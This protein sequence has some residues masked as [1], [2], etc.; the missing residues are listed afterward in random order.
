MAAQDYGVDRLGGW[1]AEAD[2]VLILG[3]GFEI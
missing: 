1:P 2:V 3:V